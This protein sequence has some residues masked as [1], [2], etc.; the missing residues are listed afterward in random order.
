MGNKMPK[1]KFFDAVPGT[2]QAWHIFAEQAGVREKTLDEYTDFE[3]A[4]SI[5]QTQFL[6][7]RTVLKTS[8]RG[9]FDV[10]FHH[11]EEQIAEAR[12]LLRQSVDFLTYITA[13]EN[14]TYNSSGLF[15]LARGGR[16]EVLQGENQTDPLLRIDETPVK[17]SLIC[18]LHALGKLVPDFKYMARFFPEFSSTLHSDAMRKRKLS[19]IR[20][21]TKVVIRYHGR[22]GARPLHIRNQ[23]MGRRHSGNPEC[24]HSSC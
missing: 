8:P 20:D 5:S 19:P 1:L 23:S 13:I 14:R 10:K 6:L 11:V 7:L 17:R 9:E 15:F 18:L 4:A 12:K 22:S 21:Q 2:P 16:S 24:A 3:S